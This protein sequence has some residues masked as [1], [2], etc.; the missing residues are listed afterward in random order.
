M[1]PFDDKKGGTVYWDCGKTKKKKKVGKLRFK[2]VLR[3]NC[4]GQFDEKFNVL[5]TS[6]IMMS[7]VQ[8]LC[9]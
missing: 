5:Q 4:F 6:E 2:S 9:F 8:G 1:I 7:N 3:L